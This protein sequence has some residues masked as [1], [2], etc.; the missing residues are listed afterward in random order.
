MQVGLES[1]RP[2]SSRDRAQS[3]RTCGNVCWCFWTLQ[4]GFKSS[5]LIQT[6]ALS[7]SHHS[8]HVCWQDLGFEVQG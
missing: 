7:R 3:S 1:R 6:A 8:L 5:V 2:K 4:E